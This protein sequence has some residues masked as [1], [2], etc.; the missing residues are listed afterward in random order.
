MHRLNKELLD[1]VKN[2]ESIFQFIERSSL[3]GMWYWDLENP[4]HEWMSESFWKTLGYDPASKKHLVSEWQDLIHPDDL[5]VAI[6]SIEKHLADPSHPYDQLVRYKHKNGNTVWIR[7]RGLATRDENGKPIRMLGA[8]TDVTELKAKEETLTKTL[9]LRDKF[10]ARMSHEIRTPLFGLIGLAENLKEQVS[11]PSVLQKLTTMEACGHQLQTLLNDIL[12][13]SR[14]DEDKLQVSKE[15]VRLNDILNYLK[16]LYLPACEDKGISL[17]ISEQFKRLHV[18]TDQVRLTQIL[19]NLLSNAIKYTNEGNVSL[20]CDLLDNHSVRLTVADNGI[21][22]KNVETVMGEY[23]QENTGYEEAIYGTGLGLDIVLKLAKMLGHTFDLQSQYGVGTQASLIVDLAAAPVLQNQRKKASNLISDIS[24]AS[25]LVTDDNEINREVVNSMLQH[26]GCSLDFA[27]DGQEAVDLVT[28]EKR[29][30]DIILMDINMPVKDGYKATA[31]IRR[32]D[33]IKQPLIIA[34][35]A[36]AFDE[37]IKRCE[38]QGMDGHLAK[39]FTKAQLLDTIKRF[40]T[41]T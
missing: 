5:A 15:V 12:T 3:D 2:D 32:L 16:E 11:D 22:I 21:G 23:N 1:L 14:L 29:Q 4:E 7:C 8:H 6:S 24:G 26:Q 38:Q 30:Y 35:S 37:T 13:L 36:D 33:S 40:F 31:D 18:K 10:F 19:S 27:K 17:I 34:L 20:E 41:S 25:I 39:P 9:K 28:V